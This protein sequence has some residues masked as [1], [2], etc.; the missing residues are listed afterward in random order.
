MRSLRFSTLVHYYTRNSADAQQRG[1]TTVSLRVVGGA[2]VAPASAQGSL[3]QLSMTAADMSASAGIPPPPQDV[4][5]APAATAAAAVPLLPLPQAQRI[6]SADRAAT[7]AAASAPSRPASQSG[8]GKPSSAGRRPASGTGSGDSKTCNCRNS[9]CLKLYCE[10]FASG[11][12]C[13]NCNC[14]N[15][16]NN[17]MHEAA[18]SKAIENILERNPNAF[19]PKIQFQVRFRNNL[20][21]WHTV[22]P[23]SQHCHTQPVPDRLSD[24]FHALVVPM[25]MTE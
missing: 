21:I 5:P 3:L 6:A 13:S 24:C 8:Q 10:C 4:P 11:R 23:A 18:R 25:F 15:C 19:R 14:A 20:H 17:T 9:K 16:M 1:L 12:Y 22:D 2:G 7:A